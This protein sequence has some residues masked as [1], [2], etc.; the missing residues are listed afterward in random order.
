MRLRKA[1]IIVLIL[2][3]VGF[4][5]YL[6]ISIFS[7]KINQQKNVQEYCKVR[8]AYNESS[9]FWEFSGDFETKGFTTQD[10]CNNYCGKVRMGFAGL[11]DSIK[12]IFG[13]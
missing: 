11:L 5:I 2:A 4:Q 10:E 9:Y 12:N 13:K 6:V 7:D 1:L 8:C 3:L